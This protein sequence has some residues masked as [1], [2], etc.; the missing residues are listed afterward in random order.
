MERAGELA[1]VLFTDIVGSTERAA[2]MGNR[3]WRELLERHN[4]LVR[5]EID[6]FGGFEVNTVGDAFV[7]TFDRPGQGIRCACAVRDAVGR[8]GLRIRGGLHT[9]ELEAVDGSVGGIAVHTGARVA[10]KAAAGEVLVSS[11]VHDVV[12]GLG[13][14]FEDR[15]LHQLKGVPGEWRLFAVTSVPSDEGPRPRL[16]WRIPQPR[17]PAMLPLGTLTAGLVVLFAVIVLRYNLDWKAAGAGAIVAGLVEV[18]A[19]W[20]LRRS[21]RRKRILKTMGILGAI[22][23]VGA[24]VLGFAA[25]APDPPRVLILP[26]NSS[27]S[28]YLETSALASGVA[29]LLREQLATSAFLRPVPTLVVQ[30]LYRALGVGPDGPRSRDEAGHLFKASGASYLALVEPAAAD[31]VSVEL[32]DSVEDWRPLDRIPLARL[33]PEGVFTTVARSAH[34]LKQGLT[35][36][37]ARFEREPAL[38]EVLP[39]GPA[40]YQDFLRG[41]QLYFFEDFP[42]ARDALEKAVAQDSTFALAHAWLARVYDRVFDGRAE[43]ELQAARRFSRTAPPRD[44]DFIEANELLIRKRYDQLAELLPRLVQKHSAD[45][46]LLIQFGDVYRLLEDADRASLQ[47][48]DARLDLYR[49]L[50]AREPR[51]PTVHKELGMLWAQRGDWERA[52]AELERVVALNPYSADGY[53]NLGMLNRVLGRYDAALAYFTTADSLRPGYARDDLAFTLQELGRYEEARAQ[54]VREIATPDA[55]PSHVVYAH[56]VLASLSLEAG[57]TSGA[58]A[59]IESAARLIGPR[60]GGDERLRQVVLFLRGEMAKLSGNQADLARVVSEMEA[61]GVETPE[62]H[63]SRARLAFLSGD[64]ANGWRELDAAAGSATQS[65]RPTYL[66]ELGEVRR[67]A[68]DL[69]EAEQAYRQVLEINPQFARAHFGLGM[70]YAAAGDSTGAR[71]HLDQ[72]L[73]I[74]SRADSTLPYVREARATLTGLQSS[75]RGR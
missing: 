44:R 70:T 25:P 36:P 30:D 27:D 35:S 57:D 46:E 75:T 64:S 32:F 55:D 38:E 34:A 33:D 5:R 7:A 2:E 62:L 22:L 49:R 63:V 41:R 74:W 13:F 50:E 39:S 24:L 54:L 15:G 3:S 48:W 69:T 31:S 16:R 65:A 23:F 29:G 43:L 47:F 21:H 4:A 6:R 9:G 18:S 11:T 59:D 68:G 28:N 10:A 40:A 17:N 72:F 73:E 26:F 56:V 20:W 61:G 12:A 67:H 19:L 71:R 51:N 14:G 45:T 37:L 66:F 60:P 8:L 1:T 52:R 58:R 42:G 53:Y